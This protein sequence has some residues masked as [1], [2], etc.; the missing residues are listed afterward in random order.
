MQS[1]VNILGAGRACAGLLLVLG[2][3]GAIEPIVQ[4]VTSGPVAAQAPCGANGSSGT[5]TCTYTSVGQDTFTVP[6]GVTTIQVTAIGAAGGTSYFSTD[7]PGGEGAV[8]SGSLSVTSATLLYVE[9]GGPGGAVGPGGFNGGGSSEFGGAGGG[10]SDIRTVP[11]STPLTTTSRLIVAAGGGG[12]GSNSFDCNEITVD[13]TSY[14]DDAYGGGLGGNAGADGGIGASCEG[15]G[16]DQ[17]EPGGAATGGGGGG[18]GTAGGGSAAGTPNGGAGGLG[19]GGTGGDRQGIGVSPDPSGGGG[20]GGYYGG[21]GGGGENDLDDTGGAIGVG[22]TG[23]AGGGGGGSNLVPLLGTSGLTTQPAEVTITYAPTPTVTTTLTAGS[24]TV[25]GVETVP[26]SAVPAASVSGSTGAGSGDAASAPLSS[27]PLSSIGLASS[28]LH[29]IPLSSIP[30]SSIAIPSATGSAITAAEQALSSTLLSDV[31]IDFPA[32]CGP[33]PA[34]PCTGWPGVLAGSEYALV[35]LESVTLEDVLQ[36]TAAGSDDQPSPAANFDS[37]D[38]GA[39]DLSSSPLSSIP[40]SSIE[41]GSLPLSS[42]GLSG[43]TPGSGALTQ[44]CTT[45]A[46]LSYPCSDFGISGS[47][48]NGVTLLALALAGVPLSSIP[49]GSIPLSSIDLADVP[50]SSIPLSSIPLS[51][52]SLASSPL[53]SIPLGSIPLG[54]IPLGSIPLGSIPL[55][56]IPLGSIPLSSIGLVVDCGTSCSAATLGQAAA[57]GELLSTAT[58]A[59]LGTYNGTTLGDLPASAFTGT[60]LAQLLIGDATTQ[61]GYPDITLGD[62]VASTMPPASYPWQS[63][64]LPTLPLAADGSAGGTATYTMTLALSNAPATV[65]VDLT[66]PPTFSYVPGSG[67][68]SSEPSLADPS[69]CGSSLCWALALEPATYTVTFKANAGIG[70]GPAAATVSTSL[71]GTFSSST[72]ASVDVVDGEQPTVD[73]PG[74]SVTLTPGTPTTTQGDLNIGYLTSPGD[75]DD[76]SVAVSAGE[77]LSLALTNLPATYDLELFGPSQQTQLQGTPS[78]DLTG[79]ADALPSITPGVTTEATPGSQDLPV[80]PPSGDQLEAVSNNPDSQSQYIQTPPLAAGN[81]VVQVSGYNGAFSSQPYLLQANLLGGET[82]PSCPEGIS[83]PYSLTPA[84]AGVATP[85]SDLDTTIPSNVNTLFLVNTERM[86]AAF[87]SA[88]DDPTESTKETVVTDLNVIASDSRAGVIGAVIPVDTYSTVQAAYVA[89][90]ANP[91][92]VDAANGVVTAIAAVV[93]QIRAQYP[94]IQNLVIVGADDQ[95]PFARVA[96][97]AT[98]SNERDYGAATFGGENNVEADALSLGYYFSDDPYA[99]DQPLGVGSATLYTPQLDVGRLIESASEIESALTRFVSSNGNLDATTSL[100]TGYS[101]LTSGAEAVEA[102]LAADGLHST[103]ACD[104]IDESWTTTELE[105]ALA[106]Q[107]S[108]LAPGVDSINAHFDYSRGLPAVDNTD[109]TETDLFTTTDVSGLSSFPG[110]L[111]FSM[112]CHAGLDIDDAEV[113]ASI[114]ATPPVADWAKTFADAGALWVANTGYGYADTDTLAYSAKLMADFAG[115]LNGSLTIGEALTSAK[116]QY[117]AGNAILSPYDLKALMEST[118]YGLPMYSL[119]GPTTQAPPPSGPP[120]ET[121]PITQLTAASVSLSEAAGT[122]PIA[123]GTS[124]N[125][126]YY[127]VTGPN[128]GT[129]A[130]EFRPIEPLVTVPVTEPKLVP[131]GALVTGLMSK[132]IGPLTPAYSMPAVG[133]NDSAPPAIGDAAFPGTLQRVASLGR[134]TANGTSQ[135]AQLDLVAGQFFPNPSSSTGTGTQRLFTSMAAEVYYLPSSSP[136]V[137]DYTPATIDSTQAVSSANGFNFDVQVTPSSSIDQVERVLVL[138]TDANPA[139]PANP[140]TWTALDLSST[141]GQNWTGA[142]PSTSSSQ[143]QYIVEAV[144]AAGNVAVSNNEGADFNGAPQPSSTQSGDVSITLSG[145]G[146]KNGYYTSAVAAT[147]TS[148][149]GATYVLDGAPAAPVPADGVVTVTGNGAHTLTVTDSTGEATQAFAIAASTPVISVG[150]SPGASSTG[151]VPA[152]ATLIIDATDPGAPIA[153]LSYSESGAQSQSGLVTGAQLP[154]SLPLTSP[155]STT[156]SIVA[157]DVAGNTSVSSVTV[158][159]MAMPTNVVTNSTPTTLGSSVTFTATVAGAGVTP[160]GTVTWTVSGSAG[161]TACTSSTTALSSATATCAITASKAGTYVVSDSYGGDSNYNPVTSST[162]TV[163]VNGDPSSIT[164]SLSKSSRTYG[165]E[166]GET[167]TTTVS[168][169]SGSLPTGTVSI[170]YGSTTL[171][172]TSTLVEKSTSSVTATCNLSNTEQSVGSYSVTAAY[173]GDT[174]NAGATSSPQSFSVS[175]DSTF[176]VMQGLPIT[177]AYGSEQKVVFGV[178]ILTGNGEVLPAT[179]SVT[180]NVGTASCVA[181]MTPTPPVGAIGSCSITASSLVVSSYKVSTS[182]LGD[183]DLKSSSATA[184]V[185]LTVTGASTT[186]GLSVSSS[187]VTYGNETSEV[188]SA[189][190]TSSAGT[191]TGT[192]AVGSSAGTVCTITLSSGPGSCHLAATQLAVGTVKNVVATYSASGNFAGSSSSPASSFAVSKDATTTKVSEAPTTVASGEESAAVFT[193]TVTT[194]HSEAVPSKET[195]KVTVGSTSC[196]V[197]LSAGT[198]TCKIANSALAVGSYG[199]SAAYSGDANLSSSSGT[200]ATNLTVS[201]A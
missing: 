62:L 110:E 33:A 139:N 200:S 164:L 36:D 157:T 176:T 167:F 63:V 162:D 193:V 43:T 98:E 78:Q 144:D 10:A 181:S 159:V 101:F 37:V 18:A 34:Q 187:S 73:T 135:G 87:G 49:L 136:L 160:T 120:T 192:V 97:G 50:L 90:N 53:G 131:H 28:P 39:L 121:D 75:L 152:G 113:D 123:P 44:W 61:A 127:E 27:I 117:A 32:G 65:L 83:Y 128:G 171:C 174:Y 85:P 194:A 100:T 70:L 92:S 91:C 118:F 115:D 71:N 55:G 30:L 64:S 133:S 86:S 24:P 76:W 82:A 190:V 138:Y 46:S 196:T 68:I 4:D 22:A 129:Q 38:L 21:G 93:D 147:I 140:A 96:D 52:I 142:G 143:A 134:F 25:A 125:G 146:P 179:E 95:I 180:V 182:Y 74:D 12:S 80:T 184:L 106:G 99:T 29:S 77:E 48:D 72:S 8:V 197:Q 81:Y 17:D 11:Y 7:S 109:S 165:A 40:L 172:S 124:S 199:V 108:C 58:L 112:G 1:K 122:L 201:K 84:S 150:T 60:S 14:G 158:K 163:T 5:D 169:T 47:S 3:A 51:S 19:V 154:L 191:P 23:G 9:V 141:D 114:D 178:A 59:D 185:G 116:Q 89:W 175:Q 45:L 137:N 153:T 156:V 56:S 189:T 198:G 6:A 57:D 104:L 102:N 130:T 145:T 15:I 126:S 149:S 26:E 119:N 94:T 183:P 42:I 186:T 105:A 103:S 111:L 2:L 88:F 132:D 148:L 13:G 188:F 155:G 31:S 161:I 54:S 16:V 69:P 168:G 67:T 177:I 151:V 170:K 41:L 173:S 79:V 20:G 66:L 35:P 107:G 195:V 166:S